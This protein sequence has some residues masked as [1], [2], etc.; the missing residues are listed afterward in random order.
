[1]RLFGLSIRGPAHRMRRRQFPRLSVLPPPMVKLGQPS[2]MFGHI[3]S[4]RASGHIRDVEANGSGGFDTL[5]R[6]A[7]EMIVG[8]VLHRVRRDDLARGFDT[9]AARDR[10]DGVVRDL[11]A[12]LPTAA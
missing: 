4:W 11:P 6:A 5:P 12:I 2:R 9:P 1:M 7:M 10:R 3:R 8:R